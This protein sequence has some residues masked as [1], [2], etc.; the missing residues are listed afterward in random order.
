MNEV[1][2]KVQKLKLIKNY[3]GYQDVVEEVRMTAHMENESKVR[4]FRVVI[5]H[6]DLSNV[7]ENFVNKFDLT[8]EIVVGWALKNLTDKEK[9]DI[10]KDL[11][12]K[13]SPTEY[14]Y[15]PPFAEE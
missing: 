2:Y 4:A 11:I 10:R 1:T 7:G 13:L 14:Y 3:N 12:E 6:L 9:D 8:K 5:V 15:D